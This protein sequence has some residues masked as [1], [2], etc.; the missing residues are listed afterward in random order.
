[1][2]LSQARDQTVLPLMVVCPA[3]RLQ[4]RNLRSGMQMLLVPLHLRAAPP[5]P[6]LS[7]LLLH[8]GVVVGLPLGA[9][10][11]LRL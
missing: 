2:E 7:T 1:M 4:Y 5:K 9:M 11:C 10:E 3:F 6:Q 8:L